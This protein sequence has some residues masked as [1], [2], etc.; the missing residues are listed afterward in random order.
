MDTCNHAKYLHM[1]KFYW[2]RFVLICDIEY[3]PLPS[4]WRW[5]MWPESSCCSSCSLRH[6]VG[7]CRSGDAIAERLN[8]WP[9]E[10]HLNA[11]WCSSRESWDALLWDSKQTD[12][13]C[14]WFITFD[15]GREVSKARTV[16]TVGLYRYSCV[17]SIHSLDNII[18]RA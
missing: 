5:E 16:S 13:I 6:D 8:I 12:N 15:R 10:R 3:N 2:K 11:K 18:I 1:T 9:A 14:A 4:I 17:Y 7:G